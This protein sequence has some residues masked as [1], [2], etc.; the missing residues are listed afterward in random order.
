MI[1]ITLLRRNS[2]IYAVVLLLAG[3]AFLVIA[4]NREGISQNQPAR[5]AAPELSVIELTPR[6]V[7]TYVEFIGNTDASD[8]VEIRARVDGYVEQ[9]FFET[10]QMVQKGQRLYILDQRTYQ[11]EMQKAKAAVTKA[12]AG[13][14]YAKEGVEVLQAEALMLQS[15]AKLIQAQQDVARYTPLV[16]EE[17]APQQELDAA[18]ANQRGLGEEVKARKAQVTQT[19]LTQKTQIALA[20]AELEAAKANLRLAELNLEYTEIM[21]PVGGRIGETQILTGGLATKMSPTPM[22]LLSPLDP[23]QV[24]I[25]VGEKEY[26]GF[27]QK[28]ARAGEEQPA[29]KDQ[30]HAFQLLLGDGSVYPHP[31]KFRS[32]DRTVDPQTGTLEL[33]LDFPNPQST[34]LPGV[35][36]RVLVK[37]NEKS[38]V[39]LVPQ[40]AVMELQGNRSVYIVGADNQVAA[41]PVKATDRVGSLWVIEDGL[42]PGD[43]VIVE[44]LQ[45]VKPGMAVQVKVIPEPALDQAAAPAA[46]P[47]AR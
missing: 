9:T 21:A 6:T 16:K 31:G 46:K 40:R 29:V 36:S 14:Q 8:T 25:K 45:Q 39:L 32:A 19:K 28:L 10:G 2:V 24:K 15:E 42:R 17:A 5:G 34:L 35:F 26:L 33:V 1:Q 37:S 11:A 22:T 12:E 47:V 3:I 27:I 18:I 43:R 4:G 38:G 30:P 20:A 44:G 13:V 7:P 23:I 41:R